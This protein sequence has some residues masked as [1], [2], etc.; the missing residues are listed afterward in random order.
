[1]TTPQAIEARAVADREKRAV[2]IASIVAAVALT[3]TKLTV[4]ICTNSLGILAEAAHSG[5]DLVAAGVTLWAVRMS[6]LPADKNHTYGHGK[7]ENLSALIEMLLLLATCVWILYEAAQRLLSPKPVDANLWAFAVVL[8][9]MVVDFFRARALGRAA[10]KYDS[11]A[12]KAD[13]LHFSTDIASSAVVFI[14]LVAVASAGYFHLPGLAKADAIAALGVAIIVIWISLQLGKASVDELLDKIPE[15]LREDVAAAAARVPGVKEVKQVRVRRSGPEVF[16]DI[17]LTVDH[18][19]AF[20]G[21]HDIADQTEAAIRTLFPAADV[22]VHVEPATGRD[23]DATTA[24]RLLATRHGLAAHNIHVC[25]QDGHRWVELHLEVDAGLRLEDAHHKAAEFEHALRGAYPDLTRIVT[26]LEP[27]GD[28]SA[29]RHSE[30]TDTR[31]VA[32]ALREF[33]ITNGLTMEP[34]DLVVQMEHGELAV[35]F[36]CV[37]Q[38]DTTVRDAHGLTQRLETFLRTRVPDI[39]RVLIQVEPK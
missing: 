26:H 31:R 5:L 12:L 8:F 29:V 6:S 34:H 28:P 19:A 15:E 16:A 3:T 10:R 36:H 39:G 18:A 25:Y 23:E 9:S 4:G 14:G 35:S 11:Q 7:F 38:P 2:A 1:M 13:A 27:A 24:I 21:A 17:T 32:Q 30:A 33:T 22:L 20:E 37:L